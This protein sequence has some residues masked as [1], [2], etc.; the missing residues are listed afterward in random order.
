MENA[1]RHFEYTTHESYHLSEIAIYGNT[2]IQFLVIWFGV[3]IIAPSGDGNTYVR[4]V[5]YVTCHCHDN[6]YILTGIFANNIL[7]NSVFFDLDF[8]R[9]IVKAIEP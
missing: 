2:Q 7:T 6:C 3:V 5:K 8:G 4:C 1:R 9:I